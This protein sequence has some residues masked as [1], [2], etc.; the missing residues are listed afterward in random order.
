MPEKSEPECQQC[1]SCCRG[2]SL[3]GNQTLEASIKSQREDRGPD[4]EKQARENALLRRIMI[5]KP[6]GK[7]S[8][9]SFHNYRCRMLWHNK[10]TGKW[11]CLIH[12][13]KPNMCKK[14]EPGHPTL[15]NNVPCR[16]EKL[17][18]DKLHPPVLVEVGMP[19]EEPI[20]NEQD[21]GEEK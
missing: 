13:S 12:D 1:G 3:R 14:F 8:Y 10:F 4:S 18:Y 9:R 20:D 16:K 7:G 6:V 17:E 2:F 5:H 15:K 11:E 21:N 19:E